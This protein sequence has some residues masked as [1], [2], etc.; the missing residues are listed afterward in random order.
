MRLISALLESPQNLLWQPRQAEVVGIVEPIWDLLK[1]ISMNL[2]LRAILLAM[3]SI[4]AIQSHAAENQNWGRCLGGS[5]YTWQVYAQAREG[6]GIV[7]F[8][9]RTVFL[10]GNT[11]RIDT[12]KKPYISDWQTADCLSSKINGEV[13]SA[14]DT[15]SRDKGNSSMLRF[16]CR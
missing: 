14:I 2:H 7:K 16:L 9:T 1:I 13:I 4:I 5:C 15:S 6:Y 11:D 12:S 8:K 10:I 3:S